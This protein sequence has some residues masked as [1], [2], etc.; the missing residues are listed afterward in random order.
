MPTCSLKVKIPKY[1]IECID[2]YC[3]YQ[4]GGI[5]TNKDIMPITSYTYGG[6]MEEEDA[7]ASMELGHLQCGPKPFGNT[8]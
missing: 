7:M 5:L 1:R 2:L 3:R 4:E 6:L 8:L